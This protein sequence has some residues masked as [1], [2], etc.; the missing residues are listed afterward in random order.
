MEAERKETSAS[1]GLLILRIGTGGYLITHGW[2]KL[3]M[4]LAGGAE[5]F[6]DP[7]GLGSTLSLALVTTSEF[8]CAVLIIIGLAT[9]L[10]A[11]PVVISMAV[12]AFVIHARDPWTMEAAAKAFF[13]GASKTW[14]SK[15]PALLCL[16]P[17]L[18]LVFTGGGKLSLDRLIAIR[19]NRHQAT[20]QRRFEPTEK[21][22]AA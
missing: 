11:V 13:G 21:R 10:A 12:A 14:F 20:E 4:L 17:F 9:R 7:V 19:R 2:G 6:G 16:I 3:Q 22:R 1:I 18:S 5:K 8:L 15:E